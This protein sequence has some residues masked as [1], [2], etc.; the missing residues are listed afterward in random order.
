MSNLKRFEKYITPAII[1]IVVAVLFVSFTGKVES[2]NEQNLKQT[3]E[4]AQ[5]LIDGRHIQ[6]D[7]RNATDEKLDN[8]TI[9]MNNMELLLS[10]INKTLS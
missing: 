6:N 7:Y 4:N 1:I 5:R 2:S 9:K 3:S 10:D 8:L